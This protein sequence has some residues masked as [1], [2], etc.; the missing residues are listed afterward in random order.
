MPCRAVRS[1]SGLWITL[2]MHTRGHHDLAAT[3]EPEPREKQAWPGVTAKLNLLFTF[4]IASYV[5][6][7]PITPARAL[8]VH[9]AVILELRAL[10]INDVPELAV[11]VL[12]PS[13]AVVKDIKSR[14]KCVLQTRDVALGVQ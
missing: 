13:L 12:D 2:T 4:Y 1:V 7:R 11:R 8:P 9:Q 6:L 14:L 3:P 5:P 10:R